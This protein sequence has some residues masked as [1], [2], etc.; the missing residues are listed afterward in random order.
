MF[1]GGVCFYLAQLRDIDGPEVTEEVQALVADELE[2][3][4][5]AP[6]LDGRVQLH[7]PHHRPE[8][9]SAAAAAAEQP[10]RAELAGIP[11]CSARPDTP[12]PSAS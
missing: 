10:S 7:H 8:A 9:V 2:Q 5:D 6:V 4:P 1:D 3:L 12:R 11:S